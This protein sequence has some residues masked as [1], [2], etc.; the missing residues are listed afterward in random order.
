MKKRWHKAISVS[1]AISMMLAAMP[2]YAEGIDVSDTNEVISVANQEVQTSGDTSTKV[3]ET[4][5]AN[6]TVEI[7]E[8]YT[9]TPETPDVNAVLRSAKANGADAL[10]KAGNYTKGF[11]VDG[12]TLYVEGTVSVN[13]GISLTNATLKGYSGGRDT[14]QLQITETSET[15]VNNSTLDS[16]TVNITGN[17]FN[18]LLL[19]RG[20]TFTVHNSVLSVDGNTAGAGMF[21]NPGTGKFIATNSD[22]SFSNNVRTSNGSGAGIWS[23]NDGN[24]SVIFEFTDS[25]LKLN[26]NGLNG[27]QGAP[28]SW[29]GNG[30]QPRFVFTNTNVEVKENG[31]STT[32]GRGDGFSYGYIT[33][34]NTDGGNYT[35]DVSGNG[36]NGLDGGQTNNAALNAQGYTIRANN[37]GGIGINVSKLN[38]DTST[39]TITDC[40]VEANNNGSYGICL[41]QP[42]NISGSS[43]TANENGSNG[44]RMYVYSG[45]FTVDSDSSV[46]VENNTNSG[47][48][49]YAKTAVFD[50]AVIATGN[51]NS[52]I[53]V[54][55]GEVELNH[56]NSAITNNSTSKMG[57]GIY[58]AG[59]LSIASGVEIYNNSAIGEN[60]KGADL[61]NKKDASLT[62][63]PAAQMGSDLQLTQDGNGTITGWFYDGL[64]DRYDGRMADG[65]THRWEDNVYMKRYLGSYTTSDELALKAAYAAQTSI[66]PIDL[67][68]YQ[69]GDGYN[70]TDGLPEPGYTVVLPDTVNNA[71]GGKVDL[72]DE[73][74]ILVRYHYKSADGSTRIWSM[75][76]YAGADSTLEDGRYV[77]SLYCETDPNAHPQLLITDENGN[78]WTNDNFPI[79]DALYETFTTSITS[80]DNG[81]VLG[82]NFTA[83][84]Q[85]ETID[86]DCDVTVKTG[87]LYVRAVMD[88]EDDATFTAIQEEGTQPTQGN[89]MATAPKDTVY[90]ING[91][92]GLP[93]VAEN[94]EPSLMYDDLITDENH[95][96]RL[97]WVKEKAEAVCTANG[98]FKSAGI[99]DPQYLFKYLDLVDAKNGNVVLQP[100]Q[101]VTVYMPLPEGTDAQT[102]F[103]LLHYE[104]VDRTMEPD[105]L[106]NSIAQAQVEK[107]DAKVVGDHIVF[108]TDSFSPF[109][110]VW[111]K[112]VTDTPDT[113]D[114]PDVPNTGDSNRLIPI[115]ALLGLLAGLTGCLLVPYL[116]KK[117]K[118]A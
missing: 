35:F 23:D 101:E 118:E 106:Q 14:D 7:E 90:Y 53:F 67:E 107:L 71:L 65:S 17:S 98:W 113:P 99:S 60:A 111:D 105:E 40:T 70:N 43:I 54:A 49:I 2:V 9:I 46:T 6:Q 31:T 25:S 56:K 80:S 109:A 28:A 34:K 22:V 76:R 75:D 69:G 18:Y 72:V 82:D 1:L 11:S 12:I 3:L 41:E 27:F 21:V 112:E 62:F 94:A 77:Y 88:K 51:Q 8:A 91:E 102:E 89:P 92:D 57:G 52:G 10:I 116:R 32:S 20:G 81:A 115:F 47:L 64:N 114:T 33:L 38:A 44:V 4:K 50:G 85:M 103:V 83:S 19:W 26:N 39:C 24:K 5:P 97:D 74:S 87:N 37:N 61:Y 48:Y 45:N 66:T 104:G 58:N 108:Q 15:T 36:N 79:S 117:R 95:K 78:S 63:L 42:A 100:N 73:E 86:L 96:E 59:T 16:L 30:A 110:L 29:F 84:V 68:I 13:G 93:I 55:R